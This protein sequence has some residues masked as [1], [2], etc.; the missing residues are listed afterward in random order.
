MVKRKGRKM[1]KWF[2]ENWYTFFMVL[3]LSIAF[4][5]MFYSM[6]AGA[7]WACWPLTQKYGDLF[8]ASCLFMVYGLV[9]LIVWMADFN[10]SGR[11]EKLRRNVFNIILGF[12]VL[13]E[14]CFIIFQNNRIAMNRNSLDIIKNSVY[15]IDSLVKS[16]DEMNA[17]IADNKRKVDSLYNYFELE[18]KTLD[19]KPKS[20]VV[21]K[22]EKTK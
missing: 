22:G 18:L 14:F 21:V 8:F 19:A 1:K 13:I 5:M 4:F 15:W 3:L 17:E 6:Y 20:Y 10:S 9:L 12:F 11:K 2:K 16:R 7:G